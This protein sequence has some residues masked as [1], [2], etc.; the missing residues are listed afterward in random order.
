[1]E[2]LVFSF[3]KPTDYFITSLL[4]KGSTSGSYKKDLGKISVLQDH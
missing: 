1:M 3:L 2:V 4:A